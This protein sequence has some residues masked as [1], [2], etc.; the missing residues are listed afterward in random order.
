MTKLTIAPDKLLSEEQGLD[1]KAT[2]T[3]SR[4]R[5][6]VRLNARPG[7]SEKAG[8]PKTGKRVPRQRRRPEEARELII[9]A[10]LE[11]FGAFGFEGTSTR[12]VAERAEVT[13]TLVLYY[14]ESKDRLWTST[15]EYVLKAYLEEISQLFVD[16]NE[17]NAQSVLFVYIEKFVRLS[18]QYPQV[19]RILTMEGNSKSDRMYWVIEKFIKNMFDNVT[20]IIKIGQDAGKIRQCDPARLYYYIISAGGTPFTLATEYHANTGRDIFS[21]PEILRTIAFIYEFALP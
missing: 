8:K 12:A 4:G 20:K 16:V 18:A 2:R 14:F 17:H 21:E 6:A 7:L 9:K 19:H 1:E 15:I 3:T 5:T 11:C 10:A 13:H